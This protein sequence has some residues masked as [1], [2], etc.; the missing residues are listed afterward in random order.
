MTRGWKTEE[1]Q[2]IGRERLDELSAQAL[3]KLEAFGIPVAEAM[4]CGVPVLAANATSLPEVAGKA[5]VYC[6]PFDVGTITAGL[7][8]LWQDDALRAELARAG[9]EQAARYT[10]DATAKGLWNSVERTMHGT[11]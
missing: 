8:R 3:S 9:S 7:E 5:A 6:D 4:R 1:A 10:W 11:P 2:P